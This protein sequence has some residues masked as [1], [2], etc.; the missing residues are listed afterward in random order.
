MKEKF[1]LPDEAM[2]LTSGGKLVDN[3][4]YL[5]KISTMAYKNFRKRNGYDVTVDEAIQELEPALKR[6]RT[7][8]SD[9][10]SLSADRAM[11]RQY[12]EELWKNQE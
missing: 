6:L 5:V 10:S 9:E 1:Q 11:I 3:W 2:N 4:K 7:P 12:V 8:D